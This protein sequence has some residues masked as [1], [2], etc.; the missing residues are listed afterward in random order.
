ML[1]KKKVEKITKL[2]KK[3]F[4]TTREISIL[5]LGGGENNINFLVSINKKKY[6]FRIGVRK[7][8]QK[9][10]EREFDA[11]SKIPTGFGPIPIFFD[12]SKKP[13]H[14]YEL[15]LVQLWYLKHGPR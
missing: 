3:I 4:G 12:D 10:M 14:N 1:N 7:E 11:L 5:K 13:I 9:N 15:F 6:V 2:N 8:Y